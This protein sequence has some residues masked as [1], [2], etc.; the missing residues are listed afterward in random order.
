M[1]DLRLSEL[2]DLDARR[3]LPRARGRRHEAAAGSRSERGLPILTTDYNLNRV[4][5]IQGVDV[6]NINDLANALKPAVLPGESLRVKVLREGK[7]AEQG[8]GYLDD[9][10][11]IVIEGGTRAA[12]AT[13]STSR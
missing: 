2:A 10:T 1:H 13:P 3:R 12:S 9:G 4:A 7:E 6:L 8:V 5:G 11:M